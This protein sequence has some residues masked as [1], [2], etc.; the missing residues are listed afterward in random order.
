MP[1]RMSGLVSN[2][3]T[4]SVVA[5][6]MSAQRLKATKLENKKTKLE[7]KQEKWKDL[8]TKIY[9]FY[10]GS[11][12]KLRMQGNY[13]TKTASSSDAN[14]IG[15][16][17]TSTAAA[18]THAIQVKQLASSQFVTGAKISAN[19]V[20]RSTKLTDLGLTAETGAITIT[21][22]SK[23]KTLD[24][25]ADT[26]VD[27]FLSKCK[28]AGLNA[29]YDTTQKRFFLSGK[30][31]GAD[32][33]F[34]IKGSASN[35]LSKLGLNDISF[36]SGTAT[37]SGTQIITLVQPKNASFIYN[38]AE[39]T[40]TSNSVTVNGLTLQMNGV[41]EGANTA[42]S[43]DDKPV[44]VT[45]SNNTDAVYD[46]IKT[47]VK[48]YNTLLKDMND[49]YYA[50][51]A[52]GYEP[53]SDD[54]KDA[55]TETQIEKWED[56]IKK[57]LLRRDSSLSTVMSTIQSKLSETVE[58]NGKKYALSS[59]G[60][61]T[62]DYTENGL[63]HIKGDSDEKTVSGNENLLKKALSED[64]D[65]VTEVLSKLVGNL[66]TSLTKEMK[67]ST[68]RSALN[69][70]NDKEMSKTMKNYKDSLAT[71]EEKLDDMEN[72]YFK[73]FSAMETA[74]SKINSQSSSLASYLGK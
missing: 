17:A 71:L 23:T 19:N 11:L 33:G 73:Q 8:N 72:R 45:V 26:T 65:S 2:M 15:V 13:S 57:S 40:S 54:E 52:K 20:S 3:D 30:E 42:D 1:I 21:N 50:K 69:F 49:S 31:S 62:T 46:M 38:G 24:I 28:E 61:A 64:P 10:T 41:T 16:T 12:A 35:S 60:I 43:S 5:E 9:S 47:F 63:L 25:T 36:S 56:T 51:T 58:V 22:G 14:K 32:N 66:Y 67:S 29:S 48:D 4:E 39:M 7:W 6:L 53:L 59:F 55:M 27:G 34:S 44:S 68:L 18:G 74:M 37:V 70:Y